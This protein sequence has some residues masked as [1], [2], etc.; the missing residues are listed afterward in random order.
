[1]RE[2]SGGGGVGYVIF[3][4]DGIF[5]D[6]I[7]IG[8]DVGLVYKGSRGVCGRGFW[9]IKGGNRDFLVLVV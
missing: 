9:K 5:V 7:G 2:G 3:V 6:G 1:M 4:F 8:G